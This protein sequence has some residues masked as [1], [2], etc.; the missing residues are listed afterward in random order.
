MNNM[1]RFSIITLILAL[2]AC[3]VSCAGGG[4]KE[5]GTA[6]LAKMFETPPIQ[7]GPYVWWHWM[8]PNFS[9]EGIRKDLEAMKESGIAGATIFNLTS[10]VQESEAP[11]GNNPWPDQTYRS[12]KY[13]EAIEYAAEVAQELGLK[14]GLHNSPGY[15]TTGGP[16]I[17]EDKGMRTVVFSKTALTSLGGEVQRIELPV[18]ELPSFSF[19][20]DFVA[21]ATKFEDIA[22]IA[23]PAMPGASKDDVVDLTGKMNGSGVLEWDAPAGKWTVY[24]IGHAC[25]MAFP[26]PVPEELIGKVFEADKMSAEISA[27]HWDNVLGPLREHVGKYFGKSF[28]HILIDS[29]EA[30]DQ[31]WTEG[32][33]EEFAKAHDYDPV[34]M[35]ALKDA[36]PE[37]EAV[38]AF[39]EDMKATVS[40]MFIDD[41]FK[42]ARDKIHA[43]GLQ[44]F[45]EPY[46]GPFDTA[47]S[48]SIPDLPMGEFWTHSDGRIS[49]TIVDKAK[50]YGKNLVGAEA[51]TGWPDNS[52]FTEDP[53]YLKRS[54][55]GTFVSGA[56]LLFLHHWVHQPFDDRYQPGMGMGWWGTHFGRNQTWFKPGKAFF[57]YLTRC[58]MMLQQGTLEDR[59]DDWIHR[60]TAEADIYFVVNQG[61]ES[62]KI[63]L[64]PWDEDACP[65]L[66]NP[67]SG[68]ISF[69][70]EIWRADSVNVTLDP[71]ASMFVVLNHLGKEGVKAK[72]KDK[73]GKSPQYIGTTKVVKPLGD[74]WD[75]DLVPKVDEPFSLKS[76]TLMDFSQCAD[77][78]LKYFAGTATYTTKAI[79][80]EDDLGE[81]KRVVINLGEVDDIAELEINGQKVGVFW[82]PPH[83][84]DVTRFLKVGENVITVAV[85]NNWAN[86]LIGDERL[87]ADFDWGID[88]GEMRGR[89]MK[90]FPDWFLKDEPRPSGRKAFVIWSYYRGDFELQPAGLVGPVYL[91]VYN[92]YNP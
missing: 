72:A 55:D 34:P 62:R 30:G 47:E 67:Y 73:Y 88:R 77:D 28:T 32:F 82:Y 8:G 48:V 61:E 2:V 38:K 87:E 79:L 63:T 51:F 12:E 92:L 4:S 57:E 46:W 43:E 41:G 84:A 5:P 1:K 15:S 70:P 58:Q 7:Y 74:A 42:V 76:F 75:V 53:E 24:R 56:N 81:G 26:H 27:F 25:T 49:A 36:F 18:P 10:A 29:Y 78:R 71:G 45:W 83:T 52:R 40:R 80:D 20:S 19:Y 9:K 89:A 60:K 85:T 11:I 66:W 91:V 86:R 13:W 64:C 65:E 23:L 31:N 14:I 16:W 68:A 39:D 3:A 6:D 35:F 90:A 33:R 22:V 50:E 37:D 59:T 44:L 21:K 17:D 69:A 54:A